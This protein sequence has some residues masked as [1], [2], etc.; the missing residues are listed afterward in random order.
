MYRNGL[1]KYNWGSRN[2][3]SKVIVQLTQK[4]SGSCGKATF[5]SFFV[6]RIT[7]SSVADYHH[8]RRPMLEKSTVAFHLHTLQN[9][10]L[11]WCL[12]CQCLSFF[13]ALPCVSRNMLTQPINRTLGWTFSWLFLNFCCTTSNSISIYLFGE[14]SDA[15]KTYSLLKSALN[16]QDGTQLAVEVK[17]CREK[18]NVRHRTNTAAQVRSARVFFVCP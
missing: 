15:W 5:A 10:H 14:L 17:Y 16:L 11:D 6:A 9:G 2:I 13:D 7:A 3:Q 12:A 18:R 4:S 8:R 1:P